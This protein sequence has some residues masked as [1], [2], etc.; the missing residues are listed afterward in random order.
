MP[1]AANAILDPL[2]IPP[3]LKAKRT[4]KPL[5][6]PPVLKAKRTT[7]PMNTKAV[8][9]KI[10]S[11]PIAL[12]PLAK[13]INSRLAKAAQMDDKAHDH[14]L[15]AAIKL[16]EAKD[17]CKAKGLAFKRWCA[18]NIEE[19]N[20]ETLQ[21]LAM[22]GNQSDPAKALA[23]T[24]DKNAVAN[25]KFRAKAKASRGKPVSR[26]A[27]TPSAPAVRGGK[28]PWETA[29]KAVAAMNEDETR[30][31]VESHAERIGVAAGDAR[32][33]A[34]GPTPASIESLKKLFLGIRPSHR[35][36]FAIWIAEQVYAEIT[37]PVK[38]AATG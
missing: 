5:N 15:A 33:P 13:E 37:F 2:D 29:E 1:Q 8:V 25:K 36:K 4:T 16:A 28:T 10:Y 21:K 30:K 31:F 24:R 9:K 20:P 11:A 14:R 18:D 35:R 7:K 32:E 26:D 38:S 3:V 19:K 17:A 6:I 12:K 34:V 22:I 23:D 27:E